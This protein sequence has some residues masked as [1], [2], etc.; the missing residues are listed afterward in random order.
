MTL[1]RAL[2]RVAVELRVVVV[3]LDEALI[4][5]T[6]AIEVFEVSGGTGQIEALGTGTGST[7]TPSTGSTLTTTHASSF[8]GCSS[9]G[10]GLSNVWSAGNIAGSAATIP[11]GATSTGNLISGEY[12]IL[13][14][15]ITSQAGNMVLGTAPAD[16]TTV[17]V[18]IY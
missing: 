6:P 7:T 4:E 1:F 10:E 5:V 15:T 9:R 18:S 16:T 11:S 3:V 12:R 14:S 8:I 2:G 13:S 17:C